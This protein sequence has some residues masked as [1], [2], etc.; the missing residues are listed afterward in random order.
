M[1]SYV[2][3][4]TGACLMINSLF[5]H[6]KLIS[7]FHF[8]SF[9]NLLPIFQGRHDYRSHKLIVTTYTIQD[10]MNSQSNY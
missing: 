10:F 1:V 2:N 8:F 5:E 9:N 3:N 7:L 4:T 6:A